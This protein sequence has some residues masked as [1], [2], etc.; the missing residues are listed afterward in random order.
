MSELHGRLK[1]I[2][3]SIIQTMISF[4]LVAFQNILIE[5][6]HFLL[7]IKQCNVHLVAHCSG[8]YIRDTVYHFQVVLIFFEYFFMAENKILAV[9]ASGVCTVAMLSLRKCRTVKCD[10][11]S[12]DLIYIGAVGVIHHIR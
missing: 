4:E 11:I 9:A 8:E 1:F 7:C 10:H 5:A 12:P 6:V 3:D 2:Q